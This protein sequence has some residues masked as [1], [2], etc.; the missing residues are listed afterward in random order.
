[1]SKNKTGKYFLYAIGEII[2]VVIGILIALQINNWNES[3]KDRKLER[4]IL[5]E[6]EST[7]NQNINQLEGTI[8]GMKEMNQSGQI[9]LN[10]WENKIAY[11]DSLSWH[12][13]KS[14][15][16]GKGYVNGLSSAG[17]DNLKNIGFNLIKNDTLKRKIIKLFEKEIIRIYNYFEGPQEMVIYKEYWKRNFL[18]T[19]DDGF[20]PFDYN[21]LLKDTYYYSLITDL[22]ASRKN[23]IRRITLTIES[24]KKTVENIRNE[25]NNLE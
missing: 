17:Y 5:T 14:S 18:R 11:S 20:V 3:K 24:M 13:F 16:T 1:M 19:D 21:R 15:W 2:L 8:A 23:K 25:L 6:I 7:I 12:F 22:Q 4:T 10:V 9:V